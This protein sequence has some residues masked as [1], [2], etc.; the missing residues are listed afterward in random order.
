MNFD[1]AIV[2][3][4][5]AGVEAAHIVAQFSLTV[6]LISDPTVA[7]AS[8]PCNPA[9]GGVGKGQVVREIDTLGGL[10]GKLADLSAIQCRTLNES[11]GYAVHSTRF[12][13]DKE[14]YSQNAEKLLAKIDGLTIVRATLGHVERE[15]AS[16]RFTLQ[17]SSGRILQSKALVIATGTFTRGITHLG[18]KM[19]P[20]GRLGDFCAPSLKELFPEVDLG[21]TRFKTG[22]PPRVAANSVDLSGAVEQK[23]DSEAR[24]FHHAH[25]CNQRFLS[26]VSC[27]KLETNSKTLG[28]IR[29]NKEKSPLFNGQIQGI[30]PRYCPSIEDKAYRYPDKDRHNVFLEPEGLNVGTYYPNGLSTS[31]PKGIQE[32]FINSINGLGVSKIA[33]YGYAVEYDVIDTTQLK[34]TLEH[35]IVPS[36]YFAG[37]INGTSGYEEAAGQG[38]IAGINAALKLLGKNDFILNRSKSY[39]GVMIDDLTTAVKDEPYRLFTARAENRLFIREDN[40]INRLGPHRLELNL[41]YPID[42]EIKGS[43]EQYGVLY[44]AVRSY[45]LS[46]ENDKSLISRYKIAGNC[47]GLRLFELMRQPD[48]DII[49]FLKDLLL[50][51]GVKVSDSVVRTLAISI[52]YE[53][54][55]KRS[56]RAKGKLDALGAKRISWQALLKAEN[57]SFECKQRIEREKPQTFLQ[58]QRINGIRPATLAYVAGK[59]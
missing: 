56:D 39:I 43:L 18:E 38:I 27:Y 40:V 16:N 46:V 45:I 2:G 32:S 31:L 10:M 3:G 20:G 19:E 1:I 55:I 48:L 44:K 34:A 36:L 8:T 30:G 24:N 50:T 52:K 12:Q 35:K 41:N 37:Q 6:A 25:S 42:Y 17:L 7:V 13:V 15:E 26:Q 29:D 53:G 49:S 9:I 58:L 28:V 22:T 59:L 11:K 5:H 21:T 33:E 57:I 4:G 14:I 54:Y 23:S 51:K 47:D